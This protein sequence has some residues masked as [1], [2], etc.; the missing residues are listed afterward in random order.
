MGGPVLVCRANALRLQGIEKGNNY[1][2]IRFTSDSSSTTLPSAEWRRSSARL[3][4]S[5][6]SGTN[7][8]TSSASAVTIPSPSAVLYERCHRSWAW[9]VPL[10]RRDAA[11]AW[12]GRWL[13][14]ADA[15]LA[16][17][18]VL[19][20]TGHLQTWVQAR[21][22]LGDDIADSL[23]TLREL[24]LTSIDAPQRSRFIATPVVIQAATGTGKPHGGRHGRHGIRYIPASGRR[25]R[26]RL[27]T[28]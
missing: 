5:R 7:C 24:N 3:P 22:L 28:C 25:R 23:V 19:R 16:E 13:A 10:G 17:R 9:R 2:R 26:E 15:S 1:K 18:D 21:C 14:S 6:R 20:V 12:R 11:E 27:G 4:T 8:G